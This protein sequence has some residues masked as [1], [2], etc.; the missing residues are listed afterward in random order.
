MLGNSMLNGMS[1]DELEEE[2][3][4]LGGTKSDKVR[5]NLSLFPTPSVS[6][7][8]TRQEQ[9]D[10]INSKGLGSMGGTNSFLASI[11][12][13]EKE[14]AD[15]F[16]KKTDG[17]FTGSEDAVIELGGT[18]AKKPNSRAMLNKPTATRRRPSK[19][20]R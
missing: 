6:V 5:P 7:D 18:G 11:E 1:F 13:K 19:G 4:E 16:A 12:Q 15:E 3:L 10:A 17:L 14:R 8:P 9:I 20:G 2:D